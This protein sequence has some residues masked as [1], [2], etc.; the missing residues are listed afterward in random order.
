MNNL[1]KFTLLIVGTYENWDAAKRCVICGT[2]K[3][4]ET[5]VR[6]ETSQSN[7]CISPLI[8]EEGNAIIGDQSETKTGKCDINN[9]KN[10]S[11]EAQTESRESYLNDI[12]RCN[13]DLYNMVLI[14]NSSRPTAKRVPSDVSRY[15]AADIMLR[16]SNGLRQR[17]GE[18]ACYFVSEFVTF[19]LPAEVE[20]FMP[21]IQERLFDEILDRDVQK[22]MFEMQFIQSKY[23]FLYE[24]ID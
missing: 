22:G 3:R 6:E 18:F 17:K 21:A 12:N 19:T 13:D 7:R 5:V 4:I 15:L 9:K 14:P 23:T 16:L 11:C 20:D 10:E 24:F 1:L 8:V 2:Q